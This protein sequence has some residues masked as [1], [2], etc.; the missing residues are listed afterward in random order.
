MRVCSGA[1]RFRWSSHTLRKRPP[2]PA[3]T[4]SQPRLP[5]ASE[6]G[7]VVDDEN[8][9]A[10]SVELAASSLVPAVPFAVHTTTTSGVGPLPFSATRGGCSPLTRASP[11]VEF[12]RTG[13]E[14]VRPASRLDA[15]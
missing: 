5:G 2:G 8:V 15:A 10:P 11:G 3:A 14:N 4:A 1:A 13:V 9:R 6:P 12:T 7:T